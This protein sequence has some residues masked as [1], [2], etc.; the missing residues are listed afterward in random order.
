MGTFL[1]IAF[2]TIIVLLLFG[3]P[4]KLQKNGV[5]K[6]QDFLSMEADYYVNDRRFVKAAKELIDNTNDKYAQLF[7]K[8]LIS[9]YS[10]DN[11][12]YITDDSVLDKKQIEAYRELVKTFDRLKQSDKISLILSKTEKHSKSSSSVLYELQKA[13]FDCRLFNY[14][15]NV[16][17]SK[18]PMIRDWQHSYYLYPKFVVKSSTPI[19]FEIIPIDDFAIEYHSSSFTESEYEWDWPNDGEIIKKK[20]QYVNEDGTPDLRYPYNKQVPV[21]LYGE[22]NFSKLGLAYQISNNKAARDFYL[23]FKHY[24][25]C[26]NGETETIELDPNIDPY[27]YEVACFVI[28]NRRVTTSQIQ[29][30]FAIGFNRTMRLMQQLENAGILEPANGAKPRMAMIDNLKD[31]EKILIEYKLP[32]K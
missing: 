18:V 4:E 23:A 3:I 27:F 2:L 8:G 1:T 28:E 24:K 15:A 5:V 30:K 14:V 31:L 9:Y 21:F 22:L 29:R 6:P 12:E 16:A 19:N 13:G 17:T 25:H 10:K 11:I 20:Y 7:L 26:L 32:M